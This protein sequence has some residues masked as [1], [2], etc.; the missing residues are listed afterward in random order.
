MIDYDT[1]GKVNYLLET[2]KNKIKYS[3]WKTES[4]TFYLKK[5]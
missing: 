4:K 2:N 3:L 5:E 1:L